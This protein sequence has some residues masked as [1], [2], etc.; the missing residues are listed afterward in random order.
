MKNVILR[1]FEDLQLTAFVVLVTTES[2]HH[3]IKA[4]NQD[5]S[6]ECAIQ[7]RGCL[8]LCE[9]C[10]VSS[11]VY[12]ARCIICTILLIDCIRDNMVSA[13]TLN[14]YSIL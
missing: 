13:F 8:Y 6:G 7:R 5:I 9:K 1:A 10:E 14:Y 12:Y 2:G 4:D 11:L 3:L